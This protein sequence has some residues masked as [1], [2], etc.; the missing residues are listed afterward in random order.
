MAEFPAMP[1]WTDAWVADTR[2]LTRCERGTYH[3]LLVEMW[4][5]PGQRVPNDDSWLAKRFSMTLD[6]VAKELRPLILEFCQSDGN[7]I[8]QKRLLREWEFVKKSSRRQSVR[9][10]ARWEKEKHL[11]H[12]IA[13]NDSSRITPT[14]T[15][16]LLEGSKKESYAPQAGAP[17]SRGSRLPIDF[18]PPL[19]WIEDA[20][21]LRANQ[22]LPPADLATEALKF[23]NHFTSAPGQR[24][25][26]LNWRRTW[27]V[28]ALGARGNAAML[29]LARMAGRAAI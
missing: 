9:A 24:G 19:D 2:H 14:P 5:L 18:A 8:T 29:P 3:D 7:W 16:T 17:K 11:S 25:I 22:K 10:K 13:Q 6:E 27:I 20:A 15:P 1:L 4:R 26:K 12:G 21:R 28:W 23:V